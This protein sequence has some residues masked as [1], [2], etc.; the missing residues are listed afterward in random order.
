MYGHVELSC[1]FY[2][3]GT[4]L[5]M[6]VFLKEL[7]KLYGEEDAKILTTKIFNTLDLDGNGDISYNEFLTSIIDS[8][9]LQMID[10]TRHLNYLIKMVMVS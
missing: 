3:V 6:E 9:L 8:S 1:T 10:L 5:L 2:Y 7:I 4:L